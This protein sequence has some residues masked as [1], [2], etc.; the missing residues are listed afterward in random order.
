MQHQALTSHDSTRT[1][2]WF[3]M[4]SYFESSVDGII[5]NEYSTLDNILSDIFSMISNV[6]HSVMLT[7]RRCWLELRENSVTPRLS[8][9]LLSYM[10]NTDQKSIDSTANA[11]ANVGSDNAQKKTTS[12][13]PSNCVHCIDD[14]QRSLSAKKQ[15]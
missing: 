1:R 2:I 5:P 14:T 12:S 7:A 4:F 10:N 15:L 3:P 9:K 11:T 8:E 6:R 13:K